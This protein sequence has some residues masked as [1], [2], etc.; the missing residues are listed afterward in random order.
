MATDGRRIVTS[1]D[2]LRIDRVS[3]EDGGRY[4]CQATNSQGQMETE[5]RLDTHG[6]L[7]VRLEPQRQV[8]CNIVISFPSQLLSD[9]FK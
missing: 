2:W 6:P 3:L 9:Y 5:F 1:G 7:R 4:R 8:S